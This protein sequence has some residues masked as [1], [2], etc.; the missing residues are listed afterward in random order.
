MYTLVTSVSSPYG[1]KVRVV[2]DILG[3][4]GKFQLQDASTQDPNDPIRKINPLG[5]I[6][7]LI[8]EAGDALFDSR[9][10]IDFLDARHGD[11]GLIPRG[12]EARAR[13]LTLAALAEGINDALL[14]VT[15]EGRYREPE[16]A[17]DVWLDHQ[18]GKIRRGLEAAI[19]RLD[20]FEAPNLA[21]VTL[22]CALSYADWRKQ[23]DWRAEYPALVP[24]LEGFAAAV[25]AF[26]ATKPPV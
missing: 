18:M 13:V 2:M 17:S 26:E 5:K 20:E 8:T 1:R 25:P 22:A 16:Q 3:L 9:V 23:I 21:A 15:Y 7:A 12:T 6:P 11:G 14:L 10:I 19:D 4:A 24:W